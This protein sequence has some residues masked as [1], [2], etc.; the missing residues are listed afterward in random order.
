MSL[1]QLAHTGFARCCFHPLAHRAR[2]SRPSLSSSGGTS[3]GGGG[4]GV[5]SRLSSIHLPRTTGE[6]RS[7]CDVT[8]RMLPLPEQ[9]AARLVGERD[10]AE[11]AP[12][13]VR[14]AV[15]LRQPLVDEGVVG[16]QQVEDAADPRG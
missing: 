4:G 9:A 15:V 11:L 2:R 14:D 10:A 8:V 13:D 6:V 12:V 7:A 5:P 16:R 3:A 1:W